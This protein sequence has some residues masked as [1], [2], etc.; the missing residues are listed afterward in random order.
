LGFFCF[1]E[2][3]FSQTLLLLKVVDFRSR[4][5]AFRGACGEPPWRL[6]PLG[7]SPVPLIPQD[8]E[9]FGSFKS[10]EENV[11]FIFEES[12]TLHSNQPCQ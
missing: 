12:R 3:L 5:L 8:K 10:H 6:A 4:M 2:R 11:K 9:G 7:V 1:L